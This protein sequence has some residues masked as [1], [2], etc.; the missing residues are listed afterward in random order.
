MQV[1]PQRCQPISADLRFPSDP[2]GTAEHRGEA[3]GDGAPVP[4]AV[5]QATLTAVYDRQGISG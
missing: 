2:W 1:P 5:M 3:F 4:F